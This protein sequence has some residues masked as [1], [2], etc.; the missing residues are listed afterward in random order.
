MPVLADLPRI[1]GCA[2]IDATFTASIVKLPAPI[3]PTVCGFCFKIYGRITGLLVTSA[4]RS[5]LLATSD[6]DAWWTLQ[7]AIYDAPQHFSMVLPLIRDRANGDAEVLRIHW[8]LAR[9]TAS[10]FDVLVTMTTSTKTSEVR[11]KPSTHRHLCQRFME[12]RRTGDPRSTLW[13]GRQGGC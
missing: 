7:N 8:R 6:A 9:R 2:L 11:P 13:L 5:H 12:A 10:R 3:K 4:D 1:A